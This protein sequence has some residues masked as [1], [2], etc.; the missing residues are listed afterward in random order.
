MVALSSLIKKTCTLDGKYCSQREMDLLA[1]L[2]MDFW[3]LLCLQYF[4]FVTLYAENASMFENDAIGP[5]E[6]RGTAIVQL[7]LF[8]DYMFWWIFF[9]H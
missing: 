2:E 7:P 1:P 9:F 5:F 6:F 4:V 3:L 8:F